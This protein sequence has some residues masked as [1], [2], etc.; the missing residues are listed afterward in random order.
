MSKKKKAKWYAV[1]KGYVIGLFNTWDECQRAINGFSGS[2]YKSFPT[3]SEAFKYF[4]EYA[5]SN[6]AASRMIY[7]IRNGE[8]PGIYEDWESCC[9]NLGPIE[10]AVFHGFYKK[11]S[12]EKWIGKYS[13][14]NGKFYAV[15]VGENPGIYIRWVDAV[16]AI[17]NEKSP[18]FKAF[19]T[20]EEAEKFMTSSTTDLKITS[21]H[22][23]KAYYAIKVGDKPGIYTSWAECQ[24]FIGDWDTALFKGF[25]TKEEAEKWMYS[26]NVK[27]RKKF[28]AIKKGSV[29]GIY[30]SW[31]VARKNIG[32][33]NNAVFKGFMTQQEAIR[34]MESDDGDVDP[35]IF[36]DTSK[37]VC[38]GV[39]H[40]EKPGIYESWEE[41]KGAIASSHDTTYKGFTSIEEAEKWM[42]EEEK[43]ILSLSQ[44]LESKPY[45][46]VDGSYD[47]TTGIYGYG[48]FLI[49]GGDKHIIIGRGKNDDFSE[50]WNVGGEIRGAMEAIKL[51]LKLELD[52]IY[53]IYDYRGI[54]MWATKA[55]KAKRDGTKEYQKFIDSTKDL[56]YIHFMKVR[57][58]TGVDGNEEADQLAK[59]A[60]GILPGYEEMQK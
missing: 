18:K 34:W 2:I 40:G 45:A 56:I 39:K 48:G 28:Y 21:D 35:E 53:I 11:E 13:G 47:A 51:A 14:S 50:M 42:D 37:F 58:H 10:T 25:D 32:D 4:K 41:A 1:C 55:W 3:K 9:N 23:R 6:F 31:E 12:A 49:Y 46:F 36:G 24:K 8:T 27:Q 52:E 54:E 15:R 57:G 29:P 43:P 5:D 22:S 26:D 60:S 20:R 59:I 30:T 33:W 17:G 7:A 16:T 19:D 44:I 38:Y